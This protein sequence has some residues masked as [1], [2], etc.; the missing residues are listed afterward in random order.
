MSR[1]VWDAGW[2]IGGLALFLIVA[3]WTTLIIMWKKADK[4]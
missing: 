3:G 1:L 4:E 2:I